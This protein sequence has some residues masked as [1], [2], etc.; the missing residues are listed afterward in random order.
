MSGVG[1]AGFQFPPYLRHGG[2]EFPGAARRLAE[3]ERYAGRLMVGVLDPQGAAF[4]SQ[5]FPAGIAKLENVAGH[6]FDGEILIH[7]A[8]E[9][10]LGFEN[11]LVFGVV[12]DRAAAG[13]GGQSG[14]LAGPQSSMNTVAMQIGSALTA[15]R[16]VTFGQHADD[17]VEVIAS[18]VSIGP[19]PGHRAVEFVLA[20]VLASEHRDYLL[21]QHIQ[22]LLGQLQLV[23]I[24]AP[25]RVDQGDTFDQIVAAGREQPPLGQAAGK[26]PRAA[27][28]LQK[29]GNGAGTAQLTD[30]IDLADVDAQ[31]QRS[32]GNQRL[33][34]AA[35]QPVLGGEPLFFREAAMVRGD[36]LV[37]Q[38]LAQAARQPFGQPTGI[39]EDQ[40]GPVSLDQG[41]HAVV[42]VAGGL[43]RE[44]GFQ[45]QVRQFDGEIQQAA[46]AG[47]DDATVTAPGQEM[48]DG[49]D[50]VL[51][52]GQADAVEGL[53]RQP[54]QALQ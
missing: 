49:F 8:D 18:Q 6:A 2:R 30:Q 42:D 20:E 21:G 17:S 40:R 29:T 45:R 44:H 28:P 35:L 10:A 48:G 24:A 4:E 13:D 14:A 39:D 41:R 37:A 32:G 27:D 33:Q 16:G 11:D 1:Q 22:R 19:G 53:A 52:G 25:H 50:R 43:A 7:R 46:M 54:L 47:V 31:F 15:P 36:V 51:G 34:L 9:F 38:S 5:H 3:P 23:K 12:G 26:V